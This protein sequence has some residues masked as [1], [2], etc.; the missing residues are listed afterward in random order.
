VANSVRQKVEQL[1]REINRHNYLYYVQNNPEIS[2]YE[3]DMLYKE[4]EEL[5]KKHPGLI[6]PDSPTQRVGGQPVEGFRSVRHEIPML[7]IDNTYSADELKEFDRRTKKLLPGEKIDYV[8]ELKIDGVAVSLRYENGRLTQG[9]TRG[10]G[11]T[12]DDITLNL[13]TIKEIPLI[14]IE[15]KEIPVPRVLEA[16]GEVYLPRREFERLNKERKK[17]GEALFANPRNAAAGALKLLDPRITAKRKLSIYCHSTGALE[18]ISFDTHLSALAALKRFGL[19]VSPHIKL[20]ADIDEVID[21]C[22]SWQDKKRELDYEIDGMV[23]KVDNFDQ[24]RRLGRTAKSPRWMIAYKFAAEQAASRIKSIVIQVGKTGALTPVAN[25]EPVHLAGTTVKRA[26]LHNADEIARK[27]IREGD[28]VLVEKAGEIIP[29]VVKVV[30]EKRT[31]RERRFRMPEKCPACGGAVARD[32]EGVY[33]RCTNLG[34]PAQIKGRLQ[35]YASRSAMDIEGLGPSVIDQLVTKGLLKDVS[36]LYSLKREDLAS[37]ERMAEKSAE[38][39]LNGI[40]ASK[41]RD[42]ERLIT[43]LGILHVGATAAVT[44][45][46]H[47]K[48][49]DAL[50][51]ASEAELTAISDIGPVMARSIHEFFRSSANQKIVEKLKR[52][53]VNTTKIAEE[54]AAAEESPFFGKACVITGALARHSRQ[55]LQ[56]LIRKLGG[57]PTASVSSKTDY[58]IVGKEPGGKLEK[59]RKLGV[60]I[61]D[62]EEF[63]KMIKNR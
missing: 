63:E 23:V 2:D 10:D 16:R 34:C 46:N 22:R 37:L 43:A 15:P 38:N 39:L 30:K 58:L 57:K 25:L 7:S 4:L 40:E 21:C 29:Q 27:D 33:Y 14:L 47:F 12:G 62:E 32:T 50:M 1:R 61:I 56:E 31:G 52:A 45:A 49:I 17:S 42:L 59:A 51:K 48:S 13:R 9:A 11:V 53:G 6:T 24:Q 18:G 5:E 35:Y 54:G 20:C 26:T 19:R 41:R 60:K 36:D 3:Y 28:V 55:E 44:L 8:V